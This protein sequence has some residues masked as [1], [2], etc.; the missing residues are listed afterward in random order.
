M[1]HR[2]RDWYATNNNN[3]SRGFLLISSLNLTAKSPDTF[4]ACLLNNFSFVKHARKQHLARSLLSCI[5]DADV[6]IVYNVAKWCGWI[7]WHIFHRCG[8]DLTENGQRSSFLRV[9]RILVC[10][11]EDKT[12]FGVAR[13]KKDSFLE[14]LMPFSA[15]SGSHLWN[16]CHT[17]RLYPSIFQGNIAPFMKNRR[18]VQLWA[19]PYLCYNN[20]NKIITKEYHK[21][22][23][24]NWYLIVMETFLTVPVLFICIK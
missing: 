9:K 18:F 19:Y 22:I 15:K 6:V 2:C 12:Y 17:Y 1:H 5:V 3:K 8:F 16:L 14:F 7:I 24:K 20:K 4:F 21:N 11:C 10:I 13:Q 23:S